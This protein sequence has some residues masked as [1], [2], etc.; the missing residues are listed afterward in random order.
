LFS[1][2]PFKELRS[3]DFPPYS[4]KKKKIKAEHAQ[5]TFF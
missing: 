4:K 1:V 3:Y 2:P 5:N